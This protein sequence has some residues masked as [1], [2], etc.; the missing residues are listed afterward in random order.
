MRQAADGDDEAY[1][2]LP[3]GIYLRRTREREN[4]EL[5]RARRL[6]SLGL[7]RRMRKPKSRARH[8]GLSCRDTATSPAFTNAQV[9]R[10]YGRLAD[11]VV[12]RRDVEFYNK[13]QM[14]KGFGVSE[15]LQ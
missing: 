6:T 12:C 1:V 3:C 9:K 11:A 8:P 4:A 10:K 2:E 14:G 7:S 5:P 15:S 13:G